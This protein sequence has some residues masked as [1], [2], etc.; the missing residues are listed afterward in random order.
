MKM[1]NNNNSKKSTISEIAEIIFCICCLHIHFGGEQLP[2]NQKKKIEFSFVKYQTRTKSICMEWILFFST[3]ESFQTDG[4]AKR[5][6]FRIKY[7]SK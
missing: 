2:P 6:I 3:V 1:N 4:N 5:K 7:Q